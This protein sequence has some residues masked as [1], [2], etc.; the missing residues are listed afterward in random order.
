V[1]LR[2]VD[3]ARPILHDLYHVGAQPV[4]APMTVVTP[5]QVERRLLELSAELD[6]ATRALEQAELGYH[7]S[8]ARYEVAAAEARMAVAARWND[9][10]IKATV[11]DKE[12]EA[13]LRTKDDYMGLAVAEATVKAARANVARLR[14]QVDIA[15]SVGTSVRSLIDTVN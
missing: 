2:G 12:D 15:R 10:G 3:D 1:R 4:A 6:G 7:T 8:K 5:A 14:T 13:L 9:R 11:Q